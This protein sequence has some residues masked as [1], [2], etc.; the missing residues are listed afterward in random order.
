MIALVLGLALQNAPILDSPTFKA[1]S[2]LVGGR[3]EAKVDADTLISHR[4]EFDVDRRMIRGRGTVTSKGKVVLRIQANFGWDTVSKKVSYVDFHDENTVYV[5]HVALE[6]GWIV[7]NF[8]EL[9]D[10]TKKHLMKA[11]F[12]D[13]NHYSFSLG[14]QDLVLIRKR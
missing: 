1:L 13:D 10:S 2:K 8:S 5:G 14:T 6:D 3:W 9:S 12:V 7:Y 4:F 11:K